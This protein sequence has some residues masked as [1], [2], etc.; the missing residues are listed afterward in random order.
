MAIK[1]QS[2][3]S[4]VDFLATEQFKLIGEY[5]EEKLLLIGKTKGYGEP[6]VAISKTDDPSQE[7]LVACDLY[8]LMKCSDQAIN[9]RDLVIV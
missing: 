6:I 2:F 7:D 1:N 8:E 4:H 9:I 5:A 3:F